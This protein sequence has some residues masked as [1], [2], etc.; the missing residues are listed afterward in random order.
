MD[1][2]PIQSGHRW[3]TTKLVEEITVYIFPILS[4]KLCTSKSK[5]GSDRKND[6]CNHDMAQATLVSS[7]SG[8]VNCGG[9]YFVKTTF[10]ETH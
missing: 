8:N 7:T 1:A 2:R 3:N 6:S 10:L 9:P 5:G 4:D